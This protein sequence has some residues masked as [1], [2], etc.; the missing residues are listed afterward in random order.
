MWI[1]GYQSKLVWFCQSCESLYILIVANYVGLVHSQWCS[2][3][4]CHVTKYKL[5]RIPSLS[6]GT[7]ACQW[8]IFAWICWNRAMRMHIFI[9]DNI[10]F[11]FLPTIFITSIFN[12]SLYGDS[13]NK[14]RI[15]NYHVWGTCVFVNVCCG[16]LSSIKVNSF[17][18]QF[19]FWITFFSFLICW[20]RFVS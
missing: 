7:W 5:Q 2:D 11:L 15:F 20:L 9:D 1:Y 14:V 19:N 4:K 6:K 10:Q 13:E 16:I 12:S 8:I 18:S 3:I 17:S